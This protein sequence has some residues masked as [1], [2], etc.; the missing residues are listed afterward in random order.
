M[1][2]L[3]ILGGGQYGRLTAEIAAERYDRICFL[4]DGL[5][6]SETV[7]GKI[8]D[9]KMIAPEF[10]AAVVAIGNAETRK[11]Y[12]ELLSNTVS[13][14]SSRA[15]ISPSAVIGDGCIIEP[16]ATVSAGVTLGKG[17]IVSSGA[18]INHDSTVGDYCHINCNAT[19]AARSTLPCET[20]V[21]YGQI[22][23]SE[24]NF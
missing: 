5:P 6:K 21:F 2:S 22:W 16:F 11:R 12:T 8:E 14:I 24:S 1:S 18:V 17:C 19:V 10:D 15:Y 23:S 9:C 3:L 13:L 7:L 20:K 4:D